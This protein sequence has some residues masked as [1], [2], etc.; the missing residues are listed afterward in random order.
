[1]S[2]VGSSVLVDASSKLL[3]SDLMKNKLFAAPVNWV[4]RRTAY[5][6]FCAGGTIEEAK[7]TLLRTSELG[8]RSILDYSVEDAMDSATCDK[9]LA[10]N[11]ETL[12]HVAALPRHCSS[13]SVVKI[14]SFVPLPVLERASALLRWQHQHPSVDL[15]WKRPSFPV[16]APGSILPAQAEPAPLSPEEEQSL[17][18]CL[19]RLR[20]VC[21]ACHDL[22]LPLL[23][24]AEYFSVQP[25]IDYLAGVAAL[26]FNRE[27]P[28]V[29]NTFQ[30]YLKDTLPR[31]Q[32]AIQAARRA[33]VSFAAKL[34]RGAYIVKETQRAAEGSYENPIQAGIEAT[35]ANYD[36][37]ATLMLETVAKSA[38]SNAVVLASHNVASVRRAIGTADALGLARKDERLQFAQLKGMA[39]A[40]SLAI[41]HAGY[42]CSKLHPFGSVEETLP[43]LIRRAQENKGMLMQAGTDRARLQHELLRRIRSSLGLAY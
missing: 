1:L 38:R 31:L 40:L 26:E 5:S 42:L 28:L 36:R 10:G 16:L 11:L 27:F 9:N 3:M 13:H 29:V 20:A 8:L 37:C 24:D 30:C 17:E 25:A 19:E 43:Y 7:A 23:I 34:V 18:A 6:H 12:R 33:D 15:P 22:Q 41:G 14:T 4:V 35:H 39:D 2:L 32:L 21:R